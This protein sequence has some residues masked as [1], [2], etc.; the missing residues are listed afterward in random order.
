[1]GRERHLDRRLCE[2][3]RRDAADNG[4]GLRSSRGECAQSSSTSIPPA[5]SHE[6]GLISAQRR[7]FWRL[8]EGSASLESHHRGAA[9]SNAIRS[10]S[11]AC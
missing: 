8:K 10:G 7:S 3:F 2:G 6:I 5:R 9:S 1:M 11:R 4:Q